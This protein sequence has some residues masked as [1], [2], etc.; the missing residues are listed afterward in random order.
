M[1]FINIDQQSP[2]ELAPGVRLRTPHGE[3]LMLSLVEIED[4]AE[5]P[6]HSHPHEQGGIVISGTMD[7]TIGEQQ[8]RLS[9]GDMYIIPGNMPHR[10]RA[11]HGP[12][13]AMDV[14]SPIREDYANQSSA[15]NNHQQHSNE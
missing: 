3:K 10:A 4:G 14:F 6:L 7:L 1:G 5:V 12:V 11:V 9:P 15:F 8:K 13:V 2:I